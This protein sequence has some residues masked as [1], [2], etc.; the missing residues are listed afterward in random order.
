ME[1]TLIDSNPENGNEAQEY[2]VR[3][4]KI[5]Q[6]LLGRKFGR[7]KIIEGPIYKKHRIYWYCECECGN[8]TKVQTWK[9]LGGTTKSCGCWKIENGYTANLRHGEAKNGK[10]SP[11]LKMFY[12]AKSRAKKSKIPFTISLSDLVI[13]E[14]CPV[15]GIPLFWG[16]GHCSDN[17]PSLDQ[18]IPGKGYTPG[19]IQIISHRAN[20]SKSN[21]S[22]EEFE[23][24]YIYWKSQRERLKREV[25]SVEPKQ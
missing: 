24:L 12:A 20:T 25:A 9:L 17:S 7:L 10:Q 22:F 14:R 2:P 21:L 6:N 3:P 15:F 19:N 4:I 18:I 23:K 16:T 13:P 5:R 11:L 8:K 1:P